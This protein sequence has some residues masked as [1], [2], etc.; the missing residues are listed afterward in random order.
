M[1][2]NDINEDT[3]IQIELNQSGICRIIYGFMS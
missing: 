2:Y 3:Q 1:D